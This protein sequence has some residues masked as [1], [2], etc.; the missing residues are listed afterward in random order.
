MGSGLMAAKAALT[1]ADASAQ[2]IINDYL[3]QIGLQALGNWAWQ[4]YKQ[5]NSADLTK[6]L[7][8]ERPEY[9]ARFAGMLQLRANGGQMTEAQQLAWEQQAHDLM[10]AAGM[11]KGF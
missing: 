1:G 6:L 3:G 7:I 5:N 2:A 4:Q 9:K 11:P 8:T 10:Q